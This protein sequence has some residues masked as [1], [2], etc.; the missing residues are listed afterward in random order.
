MLLFILKFLK[1]QIRIERI[2]VCCFNRSCRSPG[3][4]VICGERKREG[5]REIRRRMTVPDCQK[6]MFTAV[7]CSPDCLLWRLLGTMYCSCLPYS[8]PP[9]PPSPVVRCVYKQFFN[10]FPMNVT[11]LFGFEKFAWL[12]FHCAAHPHSAC[13][14]FIR[15]SICLSQCLC[16]DAA[17]PRAS[18]R[19]SRAIFLFFCII[20]GQRVTVTLSQSNRAACNL[21]LVSAV[22]SWRCICKDHDRESDGEGGEREE[23]VGWGDCKGAGNGIF[24]QRN[25]ENQK[26]HLMNTRSFF[27]ISLPLSLSLLVKLAKMRNAP[28]SRTHTYA[29]TH[30]Q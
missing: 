24:R 11:H 15:L 29:H 30:T 22:W 23:A 9:T 13:A 6:T 3:Y 14:V 17:A 10:D 5:E 1:H 19:S 7:K 2:F 16:L 4:N 21:Q 28:Y 8:N 26:L 20:P 12:S 27:F 18:S 25:R